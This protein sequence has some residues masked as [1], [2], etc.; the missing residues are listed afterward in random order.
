[1]NLRPSETATDQL[2]NRV[3]HELH[4]TAERMLSSG[5]A[6]TLQPTVLINEAWMRLVRDEDRDY[7]G[8]RHFQLVASSAMRQ[9]LI[10]YYRAR[11]TRKRGGAQE[12]IPLDEVIELHEE[13]GVDLLELGVAL[14]RLS[15]VNPELGRVI[16]LYFFGGLTLEGAGEVLSLSRQQVERRLKAAKLWLK[17]EL[18]EPA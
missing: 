9:V 4:A 7:A 11:R 5:S 2:L 13:S 8:E 1:M 3:Y 18:R 17:E 12:R 10:D 15:R 16:D 14:E 6:P